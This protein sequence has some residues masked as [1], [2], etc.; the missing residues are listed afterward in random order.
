MTRADQKGMIRELQDY[1]R[2]MT[3]AEEEEVAM[4]VRRDKDDEDLDL[5]SQRRLVA[6]YQ[7]YVPHGRYLL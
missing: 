6:L 1:T 5:P 7:K 4:F 3:R 2:T